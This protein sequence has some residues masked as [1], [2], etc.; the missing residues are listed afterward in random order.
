[1]LEL[2][3]IET[4]RKDLEREVVGRKIK[5]VDIPLLKIFPDQRTKKSV[6]DALEGA[7]IT[8]V[9][10]R[11]VDIVLGLDNEQ[12]LVLR[13]GSRGRLVMCPSRTKVDS[14]TN[15]VLTFTQGGDLRI[16]DKGESSDAFLVPADEVQDFTAYKGID[17]LVDPMSW[18]DFG[19]VVLSH[20]TPLKLLLIDPDVFVGIGPIY[21]DEIL[22]DAGLRYDRDASRLSLQ[23]LRRLNR[24]LSGILYEAIKYGGTDLPDRPF[25]DLSGK[26]GEYAQHLAVFDREG[27]LSPRSRTPI[28]RVEYEGHTVFYCPTQV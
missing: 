9:E 22:F 12:A 14:D 2:P 8:S 23:E 11:G 20:A 17:L 13:L 15:V 5:T 4:L 27:Q 1:M 26:P 19:R 3:E 10:R 28:E 25:S 18:V 21:S 6:A 7:K 24:S 16:A